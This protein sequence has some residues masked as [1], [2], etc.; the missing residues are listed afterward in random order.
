MK[1]SVYLFIFTFLFGRINPFEPVVAPSRQNIIS[2]KYFK[3]I[4]VYLPDDARVLKKIIFVYQNVNGDIRQ[5]EIK[6]DKYIDFHK[7][8][9]ISHSPKKFK[10]KRLTFLNLFT[11]YIK[12]KKILIATNDRLIRHFFLVDPFRIVL[13]VKKDADFLTIKRSLK[14]S[15]IK[16]IVVGNHEGYY[17]VVIYFDA[18]YLYKLTKTEEGIKI[19]LR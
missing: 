18:K 5:K 12:N 10:M 16:K 2:P 3:S 1:K 14:N 9:Y 13:D 4:K 15:F 6:I 11:M 7:P 17:R 8:I 19:E